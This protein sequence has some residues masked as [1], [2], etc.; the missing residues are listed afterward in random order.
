MVRLEG[1]RRDWSLPLCSH[2]V[3]TGVCLAPKISAGADDPTQVLINGF[4]AELLYGGRDLKMGSIVSGCLGKGS[5]VSSCI[6][7]Q[8]IITVYNGLSYLA[9]L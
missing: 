4:Y 1:C 9:F 6:G 2:A 8:C 3:S 5:F 7:T